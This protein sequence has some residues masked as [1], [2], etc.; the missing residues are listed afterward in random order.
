MAPI[1]RLL[2]MLVATLMLAA[3]CAAPALAAEGPATPDAPADA[4]T[5]NATATEIPDKPTPAEALRATPVAIVHTDIDNVGTRLVFHLKE[6]LNKSSLFS[7]SAA[8][9]KK[10]KLVVRTREEF[11]GR[12][13]L[14]SVYSV[15]WIFSAS[16]NVLNHYLASE[17]GV[18]S[19][20][21]VA[22]TA[23]ALAGRTDAVAAQYAYLF[24]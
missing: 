8:D 16:E 23:E 2:H 9:E 12:P 5:D 17:V 7:L 15:T 20:A 14:G 11:P 6:V 22:A 4:A 18:V 13:G 10:I 1:R 24:E 21:D 3:L 19:A